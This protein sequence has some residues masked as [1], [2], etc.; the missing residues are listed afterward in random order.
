MRNF[1]LKEKL[2]E[3]FGYLQFRQGQEEIIQQVLEGRDVLGILPTG[4]GKSL[5]FQLPSKLLSGSTVVVSPLI[6]LMIDQVKQMKSAGFKSVVSLNSFM[7][8]REK[9]VVLE[10]LD[11]YSLIYLS[12]EMLQNELVMYQLI[13]LHIDLFVIDEAHCISQWGHEFRT[14]YLK[15]SRSIEQVG[16]PPVLALS[17][18]ATP[19][20]QTDIKQQLVRP[21]MLSVVYP[22]DKVNMS[23]A[24]EETSSHEEKLERITQVLSHK[25]A[26]TMIYFSS[27]MWAERVSEELKTKVDQRIAFYHGGMEQMDRLLVQQ[28]FMNDQLDVICCTSAFGMGVDKSNIRRVIHYHFPTELESFIQ[29]IGRAGRD[30]KPCASL[31]LYTP[32]DYHLPQMFIQN[33]LVKP[34]DVEG[35]L[36]SVYDIVYKQETELNDEE[37][38]EELKL[39][40]TQWNF[41]KYQLEQEKLINHGPVIRDKHKWGQ[42][43]EKIQWILE[44]RWKYKSR[45]L[46]EMVSWLHHPDCKRKKLYTPFQPDTRTPEVACCS[47]CGFR[48]E[49]MELDIEP[50]SATFTDW[51]SRLEKIFHQGAYHATD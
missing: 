13:K 43:T 24:V 10:H 2:Y 26:P 44:N 25:K 15:L 51:K 18:T 47:N 7:D 29:E 28:Q 17:A 27:R 48:M 21:E 46:Q 40:E 50:Y 23:F 42:T 16:N 19:E 11:Q 20:V 38:S 9:R 36:H 32:G 33:E 14:D 41:I 22:M 45:K 49:D 37:M 6:S 31:M 12:P 4:V 1:N 5:C 8:H 39:S 3:H 30:G 35:V 34:E